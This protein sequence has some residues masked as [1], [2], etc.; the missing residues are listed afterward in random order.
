[1]WA[2]LRHSICRQLQRIRL[3]LDADST[4]AAP[5]L[6]LQSSICMRKLM[7]KE[8]E[9][10][11]R[12][13]RQPVA[14]THVCL[15]EIGDDAAAV[16]TAMENRIF[17]ARIHVD[18]Y[19]AAC[20]KLAAINPRFNRDV[21]PV[22]NLDGHGV[23]RGTLLF[24]YDRADA[25]VPD[26]ATPVS[27]VDS[28]GTTVNGRAVLLSG[29]EGEDTD[30]DVLVGVSDFLSSWA[31]DGDVESFPDLFP[32][33]RGGRNEERPV[34]MSP[35]RVASL[36]L[37]CWDRRAAQNQV[38]ILME[39]DAD[40][41]RGATG[42]AIGVAKRKAG[43]R[44]ENATALTVSRAELNSA[45]K[46]HDAKLAAV[47]RGDSMPARPPGLSSEAEQMLR[48][49]RRSTVSMPGTVEF[50]LNKRNEFWALAIYFGL[51]A[52][53]NTFSPNDAKTADI[54]NISAAPKPDGRSPAAILA[55]NAADPGA[56]A[57][58]YSETVDVF[59]RHIVG[60]DVSKQAPVEGGGVFGTVSCFAGMTEAQKR[61]SMHLHTLLGLL[62]L[63]PT[64]AGLLRFLA[65]PTNVA[66]LLDLVR[67]TQSQDHPCHTHEFTDVGDLDHVCFAPGPSAEPTPPRQ[68]A[69]VLELPAGYLKI[70]KPTKLDHPKIV[71]CQRCGDRETAQSLVRTWA[72]RNCGDDA[73]AS[74]LAGNAR[75]S[76]F[77]LNMDLLLGDPPAQTDVDYPAWCADNAVERARLVLIGI[78]LLEHVPG[79][80]H[81]CFKVQTPDSKSATRPSCRFA[82]PALSCADGAVL[83]NGKELCSCAAAC[84]DTT[85]LKITADFTIA[86]ALTMEL[87]V[88]R[89]PGFEYTN[90]HNV[91]QLAVFRH[92]LD[93][94]FVFGRPGMVYYM[95]V[96]PPQL[97]GRTLCSVPRAVPQDSPPGCLACHSCHLQNVVRHKGARKGRQRR[98][99]HDGFRPCRRA[100]RHA[101]PIDACATLELPHCRLRAR[102]N[103]GG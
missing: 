35:R 52:V 9:D 24:T 91:I 71:E 55:V 50:A 92:N 86:D 36:M 32:F 40:V 44:P 48:S 45:A 89:R 2:L 18:T 4:T 16:A 97:S 42:T 58:Y 85:H 87:R 37:R 84:V 69:T 15:G 99:H 90:N 98:C 64:S 3:T 65:I 72:L 53:W 102:F 33:G 19:L 75:L 59:V 66:Q 67:V 6:K 78:D 57:M 27:V 94:T 103:Q 63:P 81:G 8:Y 61:L 68:H 56:C 20:D 100:R 73:R 11:V 62:G 60:W 95:C 54:A 17:H 29:D 49:V 80:L 74:Y 77:P 101:R 39:Y 22:L 12:T 34:H 46:H 1:M 30:S 38:W 14:V 96:C 13:L 51:F 83:V 79:H 82:L 76:G 93:T 88:E 70:T 21:L 25:V 23:Q 26:A 47:K 28:S 5:R 43:D 31:V 10:V 7:R 41:R